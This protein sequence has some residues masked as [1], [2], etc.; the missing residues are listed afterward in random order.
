MQILRRFTSIILLVS[1]LLLLGA[2]LCAQQKAPQIPSATIEPD[3]QFVNGLLALLDHVTIKHIV[4]KVSLDSFR[5][6]NGRIR[7]SGVVL[8]N[9]NVGLRLNADSARRFADL[10][11]RRQAASGVGSSSQKSQFSQMLAILKLGLYN[12][13]EVGLQ[14]RELRLNELALD[15][16]RLST[17][18]LLLQV[19]ATPND[20]KTGKPRSDTVA[21]IIEILRQTALQRVKVHAGLDELSA[22]RIKLHLQGAQISGLALNFMLARDDAL[23][24]TEKSNDPV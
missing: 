23:P 15:L 24:S 11:Q 6:Q 17:K 21:A 2:P 5:V 20:P 18:D 4:A 19:G 13:I 14:L 3:A 10:M 7:L 8:R 9:L 1:S 16:D 12:R 22:R